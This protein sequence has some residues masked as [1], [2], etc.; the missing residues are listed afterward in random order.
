MGSSPTPP[1]FTAARNQE[2]A[3]G[4]AA[5]KHPAGEPA[6]FSAAEC[7]GS[8][9]A[10]AFRRRETNLPISIAPRNPAGDPL[11]T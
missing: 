3:A 5:D 4:L 6:N 1:G 9:I 11:I 2:T 8:R 7:L 10:L